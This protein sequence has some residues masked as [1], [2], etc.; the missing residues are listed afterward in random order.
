MGKSRTMQW[1]PDS[2]WV[3]RGRTTKIVN[4]AYRQ[5]LDGVVWKMDNDD[6]LAKV[7][8]FEDLGCHISISLM[9]HSKKKHH[10]NIHLNALF[11]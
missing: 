7:F 1:Y 10:S 6:E 3:Y 9:S 11:K 8:Y 5:D 4:E 2:R